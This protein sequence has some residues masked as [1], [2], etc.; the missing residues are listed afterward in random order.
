[1]AKQWELEDLSRELRNVEREFAALQAANERWLRELGTW[2]VLAREL[3]LV[4]PEQLTDADPAL[5]LHELRRAAE[6]NADDA[7]ISDET[8]DQALSEIVELEKEETA[9][10]NELS[11]FR[12][13]LYDM[14]RLSESVEEYAGALRTQM[15]RLALS[16]WLRDITAAEQECI[17]C[18]NNFS[19]PQQE[20]DQLCV[21]LDNLEVSASR[22]QPAPQ[23]IQREFLRVER[24]I[25]ILTVL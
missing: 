8:I 23:S 13:R 4:G 1:M 9:R 2:M 19:V 20:L 12:R 7:V 24:E 17:L 14:K 3:G 22:F 6:Q 11:I 21:A 18:G 15:D 5:A 10:S 25:R 16:R